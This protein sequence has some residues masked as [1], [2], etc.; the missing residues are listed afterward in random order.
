MT[1]ISFIKQVLVI[2]TI[3][4][5]ILLVLFFIYFF[6]YYRKKYI[7]L[8]KIDNLRLLKSSILFFKKHGLGLA[9]FIALASTL[10]SLFYSEIVGY[11]PC[12]LCWYQRI[13]M[14]PQVVLLGLAMFK[15]DL[16]IIKYSIS[17][18]VIG[19]ILAGYHYLL[20]LN[21]IK[22][23]P[24][25]AVGYSVSCS[26]LFV[27]QFGYIT[28]PLMS[29]TAFLMIIFFLLSYKLKERK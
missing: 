3:I 4:E 7:V 19:A 20:Q 29:F 24:C 8:E 26:K 5:Q 9:F 11:E 25:P 28:I 14:Y 21:I 12:V 27:M 17:L 2:G 16:S 6:L 18:S 15:K 23:L 10:G 13:F 22:V 1:I